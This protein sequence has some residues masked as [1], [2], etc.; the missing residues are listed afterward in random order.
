M[1]SPPPWP[2]RPGYAQDFDLFWLC[3]RLPPQ[4]FPDEDYNYGA[5]S[6]FGP[7]GTRWVFSI[8]SLIDR[9]NVVGTSAG[10]KLAIEKLIK[11]F[12]IKVPPLG[13]T[14]WA[15]PPE[16]APPATAVEQ[17]LLMPMD[18]VRTQV[19][20]RLST[21]EE[22]V[23][24]LNWRH[25]TQENAPIDNAG[26]KAF[27]DVVRDKWVAFF[28]PIA[29]RFAGDLAYTEVRT[30]LIRQA[31]AGEKPSWP[32]STQVS[33]FTGLV[34]TSPNPALPFEVALGISL[35]TNFRG[36]SRFRGRT[37]LGPLNVSVMAANGN[38][39]RGTASQIGTA[40]GTFVVD[41]VQVATDH[42]LHIVSQKYNTSAKV[43]GVRTGVVPDSQ[44]RRRKDRVE[45]YV[46]NWG[47]AVGGA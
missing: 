36:T 25:S 15:T 35:N 33:P 4:P 37:Y 18:W 47:T 42:E 27:S 13:S 46:Q 16:W 22:V 23:H 45:G 43:T 30:S 1:A 19:V 12:G 32:L 9:K 40:F 24:V 34:G 26:L 31:A 41:A 20:G 38:Y 28:T 14:S 11:K 10:T 2:N 7:A 17:E 3:R 21:D 29:D 5:D 6:R 39:N 44:R 8:E